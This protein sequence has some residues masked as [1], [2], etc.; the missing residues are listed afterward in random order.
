ME[1]EEATVKNDAYESTVEILES[2]SETIEAISTEDSLILNEKFYS[3]IA[4]SYIEE[5]PEKKYFQDRIKNEEENQPALDVTLDKIK[6]KHF[7]HELSLY[8]DVLMRDKLN[9]LTNVAGGKKVILDKDYESYCLTVAQI[10]KLIEKHLP[11]LEND[12]EFLYFLTKSNV[13]EHHEILSVLVSNGGTIL[14]DTTNKTE[15]EWNKFSNKADSQK[16]YLRA[17]P[18]SNHK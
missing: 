18:S 13:E 2:S 11:E 7:M 10:T 17:Y 14:I 4:D 6:P 16:T 12:K 5:I 3:K 9:E 8:N 1:N 15:E